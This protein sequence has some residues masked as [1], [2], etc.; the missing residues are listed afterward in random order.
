MKKG[1]YLG[2]WAMINEKDEERIYH[3]HHFPKGEKKLS[4]HY[5]SKRKK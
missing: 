4:Y 1:F 5:Q 3:P 2:A